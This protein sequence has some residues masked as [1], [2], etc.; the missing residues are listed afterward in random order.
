[1]RINRMMKIYKGSMQFSMEALIISSM[2]CS[3][4]KRDYSIL[5]CQIQA[6]NFQ[7]LLCP[8]LNIKSI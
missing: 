8:Q 6:K 2:Y 3:H 7:T 1:M 4:K 5:Q